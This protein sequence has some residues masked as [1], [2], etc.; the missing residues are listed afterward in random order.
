MIA[1]PLP[2][3]DTDTLAFDLPECG[4]CAGTYIRGEVC[5][6][7]GLCQLCGEMADDCTCEVHAY[8]RYLEADYL[9]YMD[10]RYS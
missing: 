1:L 6:R 9:E 5:G 2:N 8:D 4:R 10:G 3:E 7:C